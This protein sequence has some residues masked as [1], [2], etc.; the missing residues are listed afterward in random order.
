MKNKLLLILSVILLYACE[1]QQAR[2]P[3][4]QKTA[5]ILS[6]T[7]EQ[8]KVLIKLENEIILQQL[9][10]DSLRNYINSANGFWYAYN[11]KI[12]DNS[13]KTPKTGDVVEILQI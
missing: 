10:K 11:K 5:T 8:N 12:A 2:R 6:E 1:E 9:A 4:S 3:V 13:L 7:L